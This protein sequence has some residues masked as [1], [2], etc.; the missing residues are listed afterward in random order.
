MDENLSSRGLLVPG[1]MP[2]VFGAFRGAKIVMSLI[3]TLLEKSTKLVREN[4]EINSIFFPLVK[5][6]IIRKK[7]LCLLGT[8][9]CYPFFIFFC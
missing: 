9:I 2:S 4:V 6:I 5:K 3:T 1:S 8:R 7:R